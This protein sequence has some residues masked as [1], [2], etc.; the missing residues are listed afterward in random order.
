MSSCAAVQLIG[1]IFSFDFV[2]KVWFFTVPSTTA[3]ALAILILHTTGW[4]VYNTL[5]FYWQ[6]G[7]NL[8]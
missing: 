8:T 5:R 3:L 1:F 2:F 4:N 7:Y 6:F